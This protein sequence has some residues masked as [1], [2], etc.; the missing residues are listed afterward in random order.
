MGSGNGNRA[1][2][3]AREREV[4]HL[5]A[6]VLPSPGMSGFLETLPVLSEL[7]LG[8]Q[9]TEGPGMARDASPGKH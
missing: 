1:T 7:E 8:L 6:A 5:G 9:C 4:S 2:V 3:A